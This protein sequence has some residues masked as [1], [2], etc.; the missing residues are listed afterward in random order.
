[1]RASSIEGVGLNRTDLIRE[2]RTE[3]QATGEDLGSRPVDR[4][5]L[6]HRRRELRGLLDDLRQGVP[7]PRLLAFI[8][9]RRGTRTQETPE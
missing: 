3:L 8:A 9:E 7:S 4:S 5:L 1:M 2:L 6:V